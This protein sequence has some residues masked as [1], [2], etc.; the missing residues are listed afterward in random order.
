MTDATTPKRKPRRVTREQ[1]RYLSNEAILEER[2]PSRLAFLMI[3][4]ILG[5]ILGG[6]GW[7]NFVPVVTSAKTEGEII[8]SGKNRVVQHLEGGIVQQINVKEGD[9]VS[10]YQVL[11]QF[12]PTLRVAELDQVRAR[13]AAL[14]IKARRIKAFIDEVEPYFDDM[15]ARFSNLVDEALFNLRAQRARVKGERAVLASRIKQRRKAMDVYTQQVRSLRNQQK[16]VKEAVT[17]RSKLFDSGHGSRVNLISSQLELSRVEGSLSEAQVSA[18]QA[19][20][21]ITEAES[22]LVELDVQER[23]KATDELS[24]VLGELAEVRE[25][26]ARLDDKVQRLE[27]MAPVAGVI[28]GLQINT[29]GAVVQP[30]QTLM[31]IV[32]S[33]EG[34]VVETRLNPKD[35]GYVR[36]GQSAKVTITGFDARRYGHVTGKLENL[37]ANTFSNEEDGTPYFKGLIILDREYVVADGVR[38]PIVPGMTAQADIT[39]GSQNLLRYLTRPVYVAL[40]QAFSER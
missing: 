9:V 33:D 31:T 7:A 35:I 8:P 39:T 25:N 34:I 40:E 4:L 21:A 20:A 19:R 13:E 15:A 28:H 1:T 37:S 29:P 2:G 30:G 26:I 10:P 27:V 18:D 16:L 38:Y 17:M 12:E 6:V 32:P 23:N 22:L 5:L 24:S 11:V 3:V 36:I 14:E